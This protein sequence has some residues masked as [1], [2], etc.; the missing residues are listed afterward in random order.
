MTDQ[1]STWK[2]SSGH[3]F[4]ITEE[5]SP[6]RKILNKTGSSSSNYW[7]VIKSTEQQKHPFKFNSLFIGL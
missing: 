5:S 3:S 7:W 4:K 6:I 1:F 2:P